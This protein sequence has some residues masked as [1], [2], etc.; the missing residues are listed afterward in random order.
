MALRF[1]A[2]NKIQVCLDGDLLWMKN[3]T[4]KYG[5]QGTISPSM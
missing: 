3:L 2:V 1:L 4:A 5:G